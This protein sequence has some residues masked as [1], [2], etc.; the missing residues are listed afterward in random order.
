MPDAEVVLSNPALAVEITFITTDDG[1]FSTATIVP[2]AGYLLKVSHKGYPTWKSEPFAVSTGQTVHFR[3]TLE[4]DKATGTLVPDYDKAGTA[5]IVTAQ[6]VRNL[7]N[8]GGRLEEL[9]TLAPGT[10]MAGFQPGLLVTHARP[11]SNAISVDGIDTNNAYWL[12]DPFISRQ[13]AQEAIEGV[14]VYS[15]GFPAPFGGAMGSIVNTSTRSGGT[16]YHGALYTDYRDPSIASSDKFADGYDVRQTQH[17]SGGSAGGPIKDQVFFFA[18]VEIMNRDAQGLN[19]ITNPLIADPTG[20]TVLASNCAATKAQCAAATKFLQSQMNVLTP[21]SEHAYSGFGRLDYRRSNGDVFSFDVNAAHWKAPSLAQ[22]EA[23]APNGG[24]FGDPVV[25]EENRFAKASWTTAGASTENDLRFGWNKDRIIEYPSSPLPSTGYTGISI[26]GTTVGAA[27]EFASFEPNENRL[28]L[29]DNFRVS[30]NRHL[31]HFGGDATESSDHMSSLANA[32]G[33]YNYSSLTAFAQDLGG[34]PTATN[35]DIFN[36]TLGQPVRTLRPMQ[37][38]VYAGDTWKASD[39]LTVTLALRY[40]KP[41]VT[42]PSETNTDYY[43]T[44]TISSPGLNLGPRVGLA[45]KVGEDTVLRLGYGFNYAPFSTQILDYL[46]LGNGLYQTPITV[47]PTQTGAPTFPNFI[48]SANIP[49]GTTDLG[50]AGGKFRNPVAHEI[51]V[52]LEKRL[53]RTTS[54]TLGFISS[55]GQRMWTTTDI[56]LQA[57]AAT[58]SANTKIPSSETYSIENS[59][60][61]VTDWYTTPFWTQKNDLKYAHIYNVLNNGTSH[62]YGLTGQ[63]QTQLSHTLSLSADFTWSHATDNLGPNS[64]AGFTPL[65]PTTGNIN[66]DKGNSATDQRERGVLRWVWQ[67]TVASGSILSRVVNGWVVSGIGSGA[68]ALPVSP[69]VVVQGQQFTATASV[70]STMLYTSSLNGSGGWSRVPFQPVNNRSTSTQYTLS[71]NSL[72]T[73]AQYGLDLRVSR[74]V[75]FSERVKGIFAFEAY[76]LLN[77]QAATV[78]NTIGYVSTPQYGPGLTTGT[79]SGVLTPVSSLGAGLASQGSADGTNARRCQLEFRIAF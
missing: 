3:I 66:D 39:N 19:R 4:L 13:V 14:Q 7:P 41:R 2:A 46:Y 78:V 8:A 38:N 36:Q 67:P 62:Y 54:L 21:L 16:A 37:F 33:W 69:M 45:Y 22:S 58:H 55:T 40:E 71:V 63:W 47:M 9:T 50:Y 61:Q 79:Q 51:N 64:A 65:D 18:N 15:A 30:A 59:A 1:L 24:L 48:S 53:S 49:Y 31:L 52:A 32:A 35:Y 56:N 25:R 23:V 73:T 10:T 27:Q 76:N 75:P 43:G 6:E 70:L 60:G 68:T 20:T 72:R 17:R 11:F 77:R 12:E 34:G 42:K 44:G 74:S 5:E 28:E 29:L 26:A 57:P